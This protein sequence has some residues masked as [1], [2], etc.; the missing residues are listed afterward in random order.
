MTMIRIMLMMFLT[1]AAGAAPAAASA[2]RQSILANYESIRARLAHDD[3]SGVPSLAAEITAA[4]RALAKRN[5]PEKEELKLILDG[6]RR[7]EEARGDLHASR[8]AFASLSE[9]VVGLLAARPELSEGRFLYSCPMVKGYG[10]WVQ[11]KKEIENPYYGA[12]M[13][14]CAVPATPA[15]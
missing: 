15:S 3:A 12:A 14:R 6:S 2:D 11:T 7:L 10:R 13:L 1:I 4:A 8:V 9:G 5:V